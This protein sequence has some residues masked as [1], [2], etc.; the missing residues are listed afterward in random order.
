MLNLNIVK[1][2]CQGITKEA[3]PAYIE[4]ISPKMGVWRPRGIC[5][6]NTYNPTLKMVDNYIQ[7][8]KYTF[9][10][11]IKNWWTTYERNGWNAGPHGFIYRDKIWLA[12]PFWL[13]GTH[14][15]SFNAT[16]WGLELIGDFETE[17]F[18]DDIKHNAITACASLFSMLGHEPNNDTLKFHKEDMRS[19]HRTCPGNHIGTKPQWIK[20]ISD[21]MAKQHP[22]EHSI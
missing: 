15:P 21:E 13:R 10:Q 5:I 12:T 8:G 6:H 22:G 18:P 14:S 3:F 20:F 7:S 4:S 19:T 9:S 1:P 17:Q 2:L 16:H 11:L